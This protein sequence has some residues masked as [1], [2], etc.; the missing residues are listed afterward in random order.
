[1]SVVTQDLLTHL[2]NTAATDSWQELLAPFHSASAPPVSL[3]LAV[4]VQPYLDFI[5]DGKKTVESRF[6]V[7]PIPPYRRVDS[8]DIVLLKASG[9]PI[10]GA[11]TAAAAWYYRLE[12]ESWG[13]LRRDYAE[14]LCA[15]DG[16]WESRSAAEYATLV[17]VSNVRRL[18]PTTIPKRDRRGWVILAERRRPDRLL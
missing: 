17:R 13:A 7:R 1:M 15:Q 5:L 8:G 18:V 6:S 14:A 11:F 10:I 9:G 4:L 16:F 2:T 12:P 3:H